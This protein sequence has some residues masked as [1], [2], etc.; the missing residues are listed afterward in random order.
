MKIRIE[1]AIW[2]ALREQLFRRRDLETAG[3]L[4]V[5]PLQISEGRLGI[6][7]E[8]FALP[9]SAYAIRRQDQ[10]SIDPISL[11]R[12]TRPARDRKWGVFTIHT[13]P[14]AAEAWFSQ[15]DNVG[16]SRLMPSLACRMPHA[17]HGSLVVVDNGDVV[18]R[19][20]DD[21]VLSEATL[22][23][24]GK[25]IYQART[26]ITPG[27]PWFAR[28]ELALGA[29]GQARLRRLRVAIVGLG[30]VGSLVNMQLA[31]L[32]I[33]E[34][35]LIDGDIV[36][37]SNLSR[38]VGA[39]QCD[40][41]TPKVAVAAR[42]AQAVGFSRVEALAQDLGPDIQRLLA[43]YDVVISCVDRQTPRALLN[44]IAYEYLIPVI[45]LGTA[46]RVNASGVI[47]GDAGR[48][49]ILGPGRPCLSCWGHIDADALRI[50]ALSAE[51]RQ[52]QEQE[53]Y[54][55]GA[56]IAQPSVMAFNTVVAGAGVVELMRLVTA[57]AGI[58]GS[59]LRLAVSFSEGTVK[60]N[61]LAA[62]SQCRICGQGGA[63]T[64]NS[65][66]QASNG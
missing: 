3:L 16:D 26:N 2:A 35:L 23:V 32:G 63:A 22:H 17:P 8:A 1:E 27:E 29:S 66:R 24:I 6:A 59:P 41:G 4:L 15:A 31:H 18:A 43:G 34:L 61:S 7:R 36:E 19:V 46:F 39:T 48:V 9:D 57:F 25:T 11:N 55:E 56:T 13:H 12:L 30:G 49:V 62:S 10:L 14:G 51:E 38:I 28:Q 53:G 50:E 44:R 20:F 40:I 64:A 54:I 45:D 52:A 47:S 21:G 60:R 5:E 33:G 42:Y 58:Q 37:A 65:I